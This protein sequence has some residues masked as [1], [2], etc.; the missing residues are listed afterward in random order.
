MSVK[1]TR[2]FDEKALPKTKTQHWPSQRLCMTTSGC[3][4]QRR[5]HLLMVFWLSKNGEK[6]MLTVEKLKMVEEVQ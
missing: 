4:P 2:G 3:Q 1:E 5:A 6:N